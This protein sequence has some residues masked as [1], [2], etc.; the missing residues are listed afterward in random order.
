LDINNRVAPL[1]WLM[2]VFFNSISY[3]AIIFFVFY[4]YYKN[5]KNNTLV[6]FSVSYLCIWATLLTFET[7]IVYPTPDAT[8]YYNLRY[9]LLPLFIFSL[10]IPLFLDA[11]G[12]RKLI[13]YLQKSIHKILKPSHLY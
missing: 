13:P 10:V 12:L 11:I 1:R 7:I 9:Y 8:T 5:Y 6:L 3:F 2:S 4:Y